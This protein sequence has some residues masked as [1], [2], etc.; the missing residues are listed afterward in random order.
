MMVPSHV[1]NGLFL[2]VTPSSESP[3]LVWQSNGVPVS[4]EGLPV[5]SVLVVFGRGLTEWMLQVLWNK[6]CCYIPITLFP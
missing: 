4:S 2:L 3:L 6:D 5:D 1:D